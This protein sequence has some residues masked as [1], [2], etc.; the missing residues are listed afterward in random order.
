[1]YIYKIKIYVHLTLPI[2]V[3]EVHK[4]IIRDTRNGSPHETAH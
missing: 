4:V 3:A 1:M 2:I